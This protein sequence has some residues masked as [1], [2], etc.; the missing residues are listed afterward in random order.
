[1]AFYLSPRELSCF[2]NASAILFLADTVW[3]QRVLFFSTRVPILI[4]AFAERRKSTT[5]VGHVLV[6][7]GQTTSNKFVL[8]SRHCN[9]NFSL[10]KHILPIISFLSFFFAKKVTWT[11]KPENLGKRLVWPASRDLMRLFNILRLV[12]TDQSQNWFPDICAGG[13]GGFHGRFC[14]D[15][16]FH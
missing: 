4:A 3:P 7:C 6:V 9:L 14:Q 10:S 12:K 5:A 8:G 16:F 15:T 2:A 13:G 1:M 11:G